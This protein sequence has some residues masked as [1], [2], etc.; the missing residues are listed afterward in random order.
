MKLH[1]PATAPR[2]GYTLIELLVVIAIITILVGMLLAGVMGVFSRGPE[3]KARKDMTLL[4]NAIAS[5]QRDRTVDFLPSRLLLMENGNYAGVTGQDAQL[6]KDSA[7][8][9]AKVF[10]NYKRSAGI[11]WNGNGQIDAGYVVLDGSQCIV[12]LLGGINGTRGFSSNTADPANFL[13]DPNN[14]AAGLR[15]DKIGPFFPFD[16]G[17]LTS[18]DPASP[19]YDQFYPRFF[20]A[21]GTNVYAYFSNYNKDNGYNRYGN[22]GG[23][24]LSDC[25]ILGVEPYYSSVD[26]NGM[27]TYYNPRSFQIIAAGKDGKFGPGGL[28]ISGAGG[29]VNTQDDMSNFHSAKLGSQ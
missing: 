10:P 17:R 20:D 3:T 29:P 18:S 26:K 8:Y 19:L 21:W 22:P 27:R 2:K 6:A 4:A 1:E 12:F 13:V 25:A 5:F 7:L 15:K 23:T 28:W 24:V 9:L 11:D 14:P 16:T